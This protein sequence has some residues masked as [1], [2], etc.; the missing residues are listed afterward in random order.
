MCDC[1]DIAASSPPIPRLDACADAGTDELCR[2]SIELVRRCNMLAVRINADDADDDTDANVVA[3]GSTMGTR[4][5][6]SGTA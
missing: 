4:K 5:R 1:T 3:A 6:T 2:V